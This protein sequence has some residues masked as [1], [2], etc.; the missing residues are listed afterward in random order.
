[1][2]GM[3]NDKIGTHKEISLTRIERDEKDVQWLVSCFTTG[4]ANNPF[5]D[6]ENAEDTPL[7]NIVTGVV[8]PNEVTDRLVNASEIG[9]TSMHEFINARLDTNKVCFWE[10]SRS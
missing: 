7:S 6:E 4:L 2:C 10:L 5:E 1:M 8:L 3:E 9:E